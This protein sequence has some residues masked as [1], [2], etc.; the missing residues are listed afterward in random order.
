MTVRDRG[1]RGMVTAELAV[2]TLAALAVLLMMLW[3][4]W[5]V[6]L[7]VRCIDTAAAVARQAA[8]HDEPQEA[9]AVAAA[10]AGATVTVSRTPRLITVTVR[11]R[12][13]PFAQGLP[14]VPLSAQAAVIPEPDGGGDGG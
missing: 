1:E 6:M 4:I 7:Q 12:A 5:L 11:L 8:R 13:Q 3:G 14:V 2:A 10:P 9:R